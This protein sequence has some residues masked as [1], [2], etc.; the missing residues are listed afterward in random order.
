MKLLIVSDTH[1]KED[2]L[3]KALKKEYPVDK[4]VHLGDLNG[5]EDY[6]EEITDCVCFCVRGNNDRRSL[7]P[8]ESIIMVGNRRAFITHGHYYGAGFGTGDLVRHAK[9]L[10]CD[11]V[12]YGHTHIPEITDR[13]IMIINPGS[14]TLPRQPGHQPSYAVAETEDGDNI[15]YSIRY[16]E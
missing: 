13:G 6:I 3:L 16:L 14:L 5:L 2:N 12:M 1:G 4:I 10:G 9:S 15:R 11:I 8:D 7:L